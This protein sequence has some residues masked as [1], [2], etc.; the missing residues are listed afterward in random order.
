MVES[1][2]GALLVSAVGATSL[3]ETRVLATGETAIVVA[4]IT[5]RAYEEAVAAFA[6]AANP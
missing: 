1:S 3:A 2:F 5:V 6:V 4:A